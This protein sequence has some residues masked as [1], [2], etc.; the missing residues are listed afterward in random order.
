MKSLPRWF[1][2]GIV[3]LRSLDIC[4]VGIVT[5]GLLAA[6]MVAVLSLDIVDVALKGDRPILDRVRASSIALYANNVKWPPE[7]QG[8]DTVLMSV[9]N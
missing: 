8:D 1:G 6:H 2:I 5:S 7:Q 9:S 3:V 4:S